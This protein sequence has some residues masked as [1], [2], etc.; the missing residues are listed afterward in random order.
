MR[1]GSFSPGLDST[2]E[3]TST[4]GAPVARM[5]SATLSGVRPPESMNG[6]WSL[7]PSSVRQSKGAPLPPGRVLSAGARASNRIEVGGA[8]VGERGL[9]VLR[10]L[11]LD[12]LHDGR[13]PAAA[14]VGGALR[15][16]LAMQL[17]EIGRRRS[18]D[19]VDQ[20]VVRVDHEGHDLGPAARLVGQRLAAAG[21]T[22]RGLGG[23]NT[24]PT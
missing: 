16:L 20:R 12:R 7:T 1:S 15:R 18:H 3:E 2:P 4:I 17:Q 11:D 14:D 21:G 24:R 8:A 22:L 6:T 13:A 19:R 5:A 23:K 9:R 10:R